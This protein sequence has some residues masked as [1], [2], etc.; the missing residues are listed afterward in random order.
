MANPKKYLAIAPE[1]PASYRLAVL[2]PAGS[3]RRMIGR[4][5]CE[6]YGWRL[7]DLDAIVSDKLAEQ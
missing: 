1:M 3:G 4:Q 2:G 6:L 5:L 7:V